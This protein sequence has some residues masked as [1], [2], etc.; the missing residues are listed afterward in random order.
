MSANNWAICPRCKADWEMCRAKSQKE[1]DES[2]GR[3][4]AEKFLENCEKLGEQMKMQL[5]FTF[6]ED[7]EIGIYGDFFEV[8]Y[9]GKCETCGLEHTFTYGKRIPL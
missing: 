4:S 1:H 8:K 5:E 7:F 9:K 6:R 2:Y 3:I